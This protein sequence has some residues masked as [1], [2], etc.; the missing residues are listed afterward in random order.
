MV[1]RIRVLRTSDRTLVDPETSSP[2]PSTDPG[3]LARSLA[4]AVVEVIRGVRPV[5]QLARWLA[6]GVLTELRERVAL[7]SAAPQ[8]AVRPAV[9]R[10]LIACR[11]PSAVEVSAAVDD[12]V[13]VRAVAFR[14]E[15]HRG[16]WRV[17]ALEIG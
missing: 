12:G 6:L 8:V 10:R 4:A 14:L 15:A 2:E 9:V 3:L 17:T 5:G 7:A 11:V 13:R 16:G 1:E